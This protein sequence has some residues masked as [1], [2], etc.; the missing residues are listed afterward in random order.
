MKE[1]KVELGEAWLIRWTDYDVDDGDFASWVLLGTADQAWESINQQE[2]EAYESDEPFVPRT[3]N[4]MIED[5]W[6]VEGI[7]IWRVTDDA[8]AT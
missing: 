3:Q 2:R 4:Q 6:R 5:G 1:E 7:T 8:P